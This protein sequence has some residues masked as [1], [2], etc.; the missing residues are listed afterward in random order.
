MDGC[1]PAP[2]PPEEIES[3]PPLV[4]PSPG[5]TR[6]ITSAAEP[7][8]QYTVNRECDAVTA[9][10]RGLKE[11]LEQVYLDVLGVRVRFQ[12]VVEV[13]AESDEVARYPGAAVMAYD[14][15]DYEAG[16]M[17]PRLDITAVV[18]RPDDPSDERTYLVKYSEATVPLVVEVHTTSPEERVGVAMLLE[19]AL[20]PVDWMFGFKLQLPHYFNQIAVFE[21]V[22]T[23]ILDTED[24]ARR[25]F[26]PGSVFL[27][28]QVSVLRARSLPT[29][30]PRATVEVVN[31][32]DPPP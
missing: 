9:V 30:Q 16:S 7:R 25:R 6:L 17:T 8:A 14:D 1:D 20:N 12:K 4:P 32:M 13:W 5:L 15:A 22:R 10:K 23:Q 3:P 21:P 24:A 27:S 2:L 29:L 28:A 26:R 31:P 18:Q 11:Y 19:D